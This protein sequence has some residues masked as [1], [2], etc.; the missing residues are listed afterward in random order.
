MMIEVDSYWT[1]LGESPE[2]VIALY[3]DHGTSEQF[4][5]EIK[6]D[7]GIERFPSSNFEMNK[8]FLALGAIAYNIL[9]SI[10]SRAIKLKAQWPQNLRK[11]GNKLKRRRVGSIMR[12]LINVACKVVSHA[13]RK[14]IKIARCWPWSEVLMSIDRELA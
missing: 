4:H 5:S 6:S 1:N 11:K 8:L 7:M 9:R 13:G 12:D 2:D 3:H 10:D 14:V